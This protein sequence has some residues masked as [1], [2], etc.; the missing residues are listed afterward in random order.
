MT[1][2]ESRARLRQQQEELVAALLSDGPPPS[3]IPTEQI[4][5]AK[6]ILR[7]KREWVAARRARLVLS[8]ERSWSAQL[9]RLWRTL[10]QALGLATN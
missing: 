2:H 10:R 1:S 7:N 6:G 3:A 9:A 5:R 8:N 4:E